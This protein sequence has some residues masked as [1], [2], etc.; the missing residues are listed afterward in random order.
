MNKS[1]ALLPLLLALGGC[2][3]LEGMF[4]ADENLP[5]LTGERISLLQLQSALAPSPEAQGAPVL[6]EPWTNKFWPQAGGYPSHALGHP[7][8]PATLKKAWT[9][10]IGAGGDRRDPLI[11][12]PIAADGMVFTLD[13]EGQVS[14]FDAATGKKKWRAASHGKDEDTGSIGGGL[15]YAGGKLY[16]TNGSKSMACLDA[17]DGKTLWRAPLTEPSRSAP[18]VMNDKIYVITLDNRLMTFD[19]EG[20]APGWNYA[21]V[22]ETT[23]L[24]GSVSPAIDSSVVILPQSSG[25]LL[26]LRVE[27]GQA[28]WEDNL[29][30][31]AATGSLAAI[32]D[33]RGLPVIDQGLVYA[34]SYSG[35]IVALD[36]VSGRRV[37]QRDIGTAETPW[38]AGDS[39]FIITTEQQLVALTRAA[40]AV[41]WVT[42]LERYKG[43][44]KAKPIVWTGPLLAGGRLIAASTEGKMIEADPADGHIIRETKLP[45]SVSLPPLVAD[46]TLFLLTDDG[47]LAAYR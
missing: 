10:S 30:A 4:S 7:S 37:W 19:A 24:L 25:D 46:D 38:A 26:A 14:A 33:I 36:E 22:A 45:G 32:S 27:N 34:A 6:P 23:N 17:A 35:R 28:V 11:S 47:T 2:A 18:T 1:L 9:A 41:R 43:N 29:S 20:G 44:D 15:A 31:L 5:P 21:G 40:G 8:L 3:K 39:L 42:P 13:T 12:Q 16:V